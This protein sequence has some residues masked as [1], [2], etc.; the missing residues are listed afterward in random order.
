[1]TLS[2]GVN[3][4]LGSIENQLVPYPV[5]PGLVVHVFSL[6]FIFRMR[7]ASVAC[8]PYF[9]RTGGAE[10]DGPGIAKFMVTLEPSLISWQ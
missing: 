2:V 5:S 9:S 3:T 7:I 4:H 8:T 1:M 10:R 6:H